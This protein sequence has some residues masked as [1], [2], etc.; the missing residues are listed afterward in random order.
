MSEFYSN[1]RYWT[2]YSCG[3]LVDFDLESAIQ[4]AALANLGANAWYCDDLLFDVVHVYY[5]PGRQWD[6]IKLEDFRYFEDL[7]GEDFGPSFLGG[8]Q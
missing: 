6:I 8:G 1:R 5:A 3:T 2:I 7:T 4:A